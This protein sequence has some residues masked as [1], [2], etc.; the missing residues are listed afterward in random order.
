MTTP[1]FCRIDGELARFEVD[2]DSHAQAI[3]A[4]KKEL[5]QTRTHPEGAV[6]ALIECKKEA[7]Q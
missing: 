2:T 5:L 1:V 7:T 3:A 4:V 6:L